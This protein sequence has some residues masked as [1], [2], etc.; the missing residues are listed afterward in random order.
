MGFL[1]RI[2]MVIRTQINSWVQE[3]EDPEQILDQALLN[4]EQQ[5]LK[6]R[7]AVAEA[8]ASYKRTER[9]L[10]GYLRKAQDWHNQARLALEKGQESLAREALGKWQTYQTSV[11]PI[12]SQLEEQSAIVT[13]LREDLL[14]LETKYQ[15][16]K[17]KKSLY[18]ARL[19][20]A[21]ASQ[22]MQE[23]MENTQSGLSIFERLDDKIREIEA[24]SELRKL[25]P[26]DPL[27]QHF[28]NLE[29]ESKDI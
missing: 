10:Q 28:R 8:I 26:P 21:I 23:I 1:E 13:K 6:M 24:E 7:Q 25:S 12:Q 19:Q 16:A 18:L 3:A 20:A 14:N 5:L 29:S 2:K 15:E 11:Q 22:K 27:E 9:H 17:S 4:L